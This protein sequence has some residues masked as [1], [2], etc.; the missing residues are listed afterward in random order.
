MK[1]PQARINATHRICQELFERGILEP[2]PLQSVFHAEGRPVLN[3][4]FAVE[5][6]GRAGAGQCRV[7]R[8]IMIFM[9][10]NAFQEFCVGI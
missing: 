8:L 10:A 1:V 7:T 5:K 2:I 6:R 3:G 4:A 9:P